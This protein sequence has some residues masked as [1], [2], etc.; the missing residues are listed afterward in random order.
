MIPTTNHRSYFEPHPYL[1]QIFDFFVDGN[2]FSQLPVDFDAYV[3]SIDARPSQ[4]GVRLSISIGRGSEVA[5][6]PVGEFLRDKEMS[7]R[8][9]ES[10]LG[11]SEDK[12]GEETLR[13]V[14][15]SEKGSEG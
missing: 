8:E 7:T 4:I 1:T 14:F 10:S 5:R 11:F 15:L 3:A 9:L 2:I 6:N 13:R 12:L